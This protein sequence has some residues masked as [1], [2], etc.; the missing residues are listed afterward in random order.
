MATNPNSGGQYAKPSFYSSGSTGYDTIGQT[1]QDYNK[2]AYPSGGVSVSQQQAKGQ[3]VS[4]QS[5][6]NS[7]IASSMYSSKSH[8][9]LNKV[10]VSSS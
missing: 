1:P 9:A 6:G 5:G 7:D 4:N 2:T 8:V 3:S 10:N